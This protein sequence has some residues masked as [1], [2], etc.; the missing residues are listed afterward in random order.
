MMLR[1]GVAAVALLVAL[2]LAGP[3]VIAVLAPDRAAP[4]PV[5]R[6][7]PDA[8]RALSGQLDLPASAIRYV[9]IE[10]RARDNLIV[11]QFEIRSFP[12][13]AVERAYLFSRC[14]PLDDLDPAG[15]G[16]GRGVTDFASD[17]ELVHLR[18]GAQP[19]CS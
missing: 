17:P 13:L 8:R 3:A 15:M 12:F 10:T 19:P 14:T 11:L 16:G 4:A 9:G 1:L 5:D 2:V 6:L 7:L 18:S